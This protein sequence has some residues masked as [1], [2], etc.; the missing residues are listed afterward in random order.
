MISSPSNLD[1]LFVND[2]PLID[3]RAPVEFQKGAF[4]SATNLPILTDEERHEV[5]ICYKEKGPQ[6]AEQLGFELVSGPIKEK[7]LERWANFLSKSPD[8]LLYCFR[9]G[10]RSKTAC[11]WLLTAGFDV[12]RIEGGYKQLRN[13]LLLVFEK[14]PSLVIVS[15][16]TGTGKTDFLADFTQS[17]DLEG[18]ANH[19][20]SAFGGRITPQPAQIDFENALAVQ[21]L[22]RRDEKEI[23]LEDESRLIGRTNLPLPLQEKMKQAPIMI[24]EEPLDAR[25]ERIF[26]EY[27]ETQ[28]D[29]YVDFYG[30]DAE[31]EFEAYLLSAVDAIR[32]RLGGDAHQSIRELM[33]TAI[34]AHRNGNGLDAH[35]VWITTLL[36]DYYDPMYNYQMD[37]KA[38]R[39]RIRAPREEVIDWYAEFQGCLP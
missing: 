26:G 37:K 11:S 18:L 10:L 35:R 27:I 20:G 38:E 16:R 8:A 1:E 33:L 15:G 36:S 17:I 6:F 39:V 25:T 22:K 7:R 29:E 34:T 31:T 28:W 14:L 23:L 24:I 19:R 13:H 21:F 5:G 9:G 12:P 4:P 3:V 32:K 30:S 2:T